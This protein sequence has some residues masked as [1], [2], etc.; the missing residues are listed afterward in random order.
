MI[1]RDLLPLYVEDLVSEETRAFVEEHLAHCEDCQKA[2]EQARTSPGVSADA[3]VVP[4]KNIRK[5]L[6]QQKLQSVFLA[7]TLVMAVLIAVFSY[8]TL[9]QYVPYSEDLLSVTENEN[10][11]VLVSFDED[12][13]TGFSAN[14]LVRSEDG[15]EMVLYIHAW[16]T[17]WGYLFPAHEVQNV[18]LKQAETPIDLIFY[19][20]NKHQEAI[21]I[22]GRDVTYNTVVLPRLVLV[23][24]LVIAGL[25]VMLGGVLLLVFRKNKKFQLWLER[26]TLFPVAYIISHLLIK[27]FTTISYAMSRD[28]IFIL[29]VTVLF[30]IAGLLGISL[31]RNKKEIKSISVD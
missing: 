7:V 23:Y 22:W 26:L 29:F 1:V 10:G 18:V 30:Y 14:D 31:Y 5:R 8:L 9:P 2:L 20:P 4:L 13:V 21:K 25:A 19:S 11:M 12:Q 27:G 24:Y 28:L 15:E 6:K 17:T 3:N 16:K